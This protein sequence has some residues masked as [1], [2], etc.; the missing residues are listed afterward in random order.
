MEMLLQRT[1][2]DSIIKV[3]SGKKKREKKKGLKKG[4][5]NI[6]CLHKHYHTGA[7]CIQ[8]RLLKLLL[9][10]SLSCILTS[11][12]IFERQHCASGLE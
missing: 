6:F 9:L 1:D 5:N 3:T 10:V 12:T 11:C 7:Y 2:Y 8:V 4:K